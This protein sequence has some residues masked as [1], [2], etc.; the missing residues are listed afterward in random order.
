MEDSPNGIAGVPNGIGSSL[1]ETEGWPNGIGGAPNGTE[2][3][4]KRTEVGPIGTDG[5]AIGTEVEPRAAGW[6]RNA[7]RQLHPGRPGGGV[8]GALASPAGVG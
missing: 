7:S 2:G 1:N 4:P 6:L 3:G 8:T 5:D